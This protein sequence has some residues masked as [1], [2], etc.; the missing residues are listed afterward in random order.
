MHQMVN[1]RVLFGEESL[2]G[3][4]QMLSLRSLAFIRYSAIRRARALS[5]VAL[6]CFPDRTTTKEM[7]I[8]TNK[9]ASVPATHSKS[10]RFMCSLLRILYTSPSSTRFGFV[11][12]RRTCAVVLCLP[13][14]C[15]S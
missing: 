5:C 11:P 8:G 10:Q 14:A 7:I 13:T 4:P 6:D 12:A 1:S 3:T 9:L 15:R 2:L